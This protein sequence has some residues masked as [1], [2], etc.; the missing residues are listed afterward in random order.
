M[1]ALRLVLL[2]TLATCAPAEHPDPLR[3]SD[4]P[5][6]GGTPG[7][8]GR[9]AMTTFNCDGA[10]RAIEARHFQGWRGLP[11]DCTPKA[12]LG[13]ELDDTW[14][15]MSLGSSFERARSHLVELPGYGRALAYARDGSLVLFD[16][17]APQL[18]G[19]WPAL[20][21]DLGAPDATFDWTF[22]TVPMP[23]GEHVY[24]SRGLTVF[25]N[26]ENQVVAYVSVY[27]PT[28][29]EIYARRLRPPREKRPH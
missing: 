3:K 26:P 1:T 8:Q 5:V 7:S 24:A 18:D 29:V 12:V 2:A 19:S 17:M 25:L 16:A 22:G 23:G 6:I 28:T 11:A 10:R 15:V 4:P 21:A 27:A 20:S 13:I 9:D 14:G